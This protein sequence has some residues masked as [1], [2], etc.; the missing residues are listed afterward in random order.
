MKMLRFGVWIDAVILPRFLQLQSA[1]IF[2][3]FTMIF[4]C[5][6]PSGRP[7]ILLF[8]SLALWQYGIRYRTQIMKKIVFN[9][10]LVFGKWYNI[11]LLLNR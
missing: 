9:Q 10:Y 1:V 11:G 3:I 7:I 4:Y 5:P 2:A 8:L 6:W